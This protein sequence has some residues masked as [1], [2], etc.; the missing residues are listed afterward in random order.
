MKKAT[1]IKPSKLAQLPAVLL[2]LILVAVPFQAFLS[3][4]V[5]SLTGH[6]E[7]VRLWKDVLLLVIVSLA[8]AVLWRDPAIWKK[9]RSGWL[10]WAILCYVLL[11]LLLGALAFGKGQVN[12]YALAY[13]LVI[14]LRPIAM[15]MVT[16]VLALSVPWL[17]DNWQRLLLWPA[18]IV[19]VFG[20]MQVLVLPNNFLSHFGYSPATIEAYETVDNK[21][22]YVR[23]QSTLRGSNPLGAYLVVVAAGLL[24]LLRRVRNKLNGQLVMA[25]LLTATVLFFSYSRSAYIGLV[26]A[27]A[28]AI[29]MA[30]RNRREQ[31]WLA[32]SLVVFALVV[33]GLFAVFRNNDQLEN[34][35]FH[36]NEDSTSMMSSNEQRASALRNG[37]E[38]VT[39]QPFGLGPGTAGPA[40]IHNDQPQRI[41]ENYYLQVGQETGWLGLGLFV[42]ILFMIGKKLWH[43]RDQPLAKAMLISLAGIS[44][45][46]LVQHAW[47][48]DTLAYIW[49]GFAGIAMGLPVTKEPGRLLRMVTRIRQFYSTPK[50]PEYFNKT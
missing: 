48:D 14:N 3:V 25:L 6:Y 30:V 20:L 32:I 38:D 13:A 21:E 31:R 10:P 36:T 44:F 40:S 33:G 29:I 27:V 41:A 26:I 16:W 45:I 15:F 23:I 34:T 24:V 11:Q 22:D 35:L 50:K 1:P 47:T 18:A 42:S 43:R 4:F 12:G 9:L 2:V 8:G 39:S 37:L 19:V 5:S 46:N 28:A 7:L 17:R 49:W